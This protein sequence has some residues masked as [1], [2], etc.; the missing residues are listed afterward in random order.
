MA[1]YGG[2]KTGGNTGFKMGTYGG[3]KMGV[4]S[5][6]IIITSTARTR[7]LPGFVNIT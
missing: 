2:L 7:I 4:N 1:G 3:Q 6:L 5:G